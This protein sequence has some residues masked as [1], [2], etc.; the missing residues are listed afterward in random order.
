MRSDK[1]RNN[2]SPPSN[3]KMADKPSRQVHFDE[4]PVSD[5]LVFQ[6]PPRRP[7]PNIVLRTTPPRVRF[8]P[9]TEA[10]FTASLNRGTL[11]GGFAQAH[12]FP[13]HSNSGSHRDGILPDSDSHSIDDDIYDQEE[14]SQERESDEIEDSRASQ[15]KNA[16][17][18]Y[19]KLST[20]TNLMSSPTLFILPRR[21]PA[22][23]RHYQTRS[24]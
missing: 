2:I 5:L 7:K 15:T 12:R 19:L 9:A 4:N 6:S 14:W 16:S 18:T 17:L 21:C 20:N 11:E 8:P 23:P 10:T 24:R 22:V 1:F 3:H 13:S